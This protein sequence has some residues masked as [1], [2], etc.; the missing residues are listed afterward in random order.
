MDR[1]GGHQ[2]SY[3]VSLTGGTKH[4]VKMEYY[5]GGGGTWRACAGPVPPSRTASSLGRISSR[6]RQERRSRSALTPPSLG[7]SRGLTVTYY[8]NMDFTGPSVPRI[9][10]TI[11]F[12]WGN[13]S[14]DPA[15]GVDTFSARWTG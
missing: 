12:D 10:S 13:G 3:T 7:C 14:P 5:Q 6:P 11:D 8:D 1:S 4:D 15:I 9:D 2:V